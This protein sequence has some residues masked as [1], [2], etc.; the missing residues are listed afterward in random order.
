MHVV[1]SHGLKYAEM[2][3]RQERLAYFAYIATVSKMTSLF[4][5]KRSKR[6]RE[7]GNDCPLSCSHIHTSFC[8]IEER[9]V[10]QGTRRTTCSWS[11]LLIKKRKS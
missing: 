8:P 7:S 5:G 2:L 3:K 4:Q 9:R 1:G 10:A 6:L 11:V